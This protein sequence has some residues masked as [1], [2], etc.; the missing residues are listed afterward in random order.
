M[1]KWTRGDPM[2]ETA[3]KYSE[4]KYYSKKELSELMDYYV[5]EPV[6]KE[7]ETYRSFFR[8]ELYFYEKTYYLTQNPLVIN[9][10][11]H[12]QEQLY[13]YALHHQKN[14]I[15]IEENFLS[16]NEKEALQRYLLQTKI[17][18]LLPEKEIY[19][20]CIHL[21][22]LQ[23][24]CKLDVIT[25]LSD[26]NLPFLIK[27]FLLIY[28]TPRKV[29]YILQ[30]PLCIQNG[31]LP[32]INILPIEE[33]IHKIEKMEKNS[34]LTYQFLCLLDTIQLKLFDI[35]VLLKSSNQQKLTTMHV[36]DLRERFPML[37]K[38]QIDFYVAHRECNHYYT[39]QNYMHF[40]NVCY[41]T[42]RYSLE[43]LVQE[44]WYKK[45]KMGKKFVY[46]VI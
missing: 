39:I 9:K 24:D 14:T 10:L 34:D 16:E 22:Q 21:F 13:Q 11:L 20:R 31:C 35:M 26:H 41:E 38:E 12:V 15:N 40:C 30:F 3:R 2:Y 18:T 43:H 36:K 33:C 4:L 46:Y 19:H 25:I 44:Q 42:A 37:R 5:L 32:C 28:M 45:Q 8:Y 29:S 17:N 7:I 6:W 1:L 27:L 23:Y